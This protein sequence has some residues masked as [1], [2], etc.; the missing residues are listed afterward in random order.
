MQRGRRKEYGLASV[1]SWEYRKVT[2]R[3]SE[4][5]GDWYASFTDMDTI[6]GFAQ[7]L[8]YYGQLGFELVAA[9]PQSWSTP[10]AGGSVRYGGAYEEHETQMEPMGPPVGGWERRY[11][12]LGWHV[13]MYLCVL[14]RRRA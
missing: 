8:N 9:E 12:T 7:I 1:E 6:H 3:L 4:D 5:T 10:S 11:R 14:K 13:D 2:V